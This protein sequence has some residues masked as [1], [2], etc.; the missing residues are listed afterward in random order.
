MITYISV[1]RRIRKYAFVSKSLK[2][3]YVFIKYNRYAFEKYNIFENT[4]MFFLNTT[5]QRANMLI[6]A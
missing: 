5:P 3:K 4:S 2:V 1:F 6:L